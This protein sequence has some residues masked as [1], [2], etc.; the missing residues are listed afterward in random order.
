MIRV[1]HIYILF[2]AFAN[3]VYN[4][5]DSDI[6]LVAISDCTLDDLRRINES[7][8]S[9]NSTA[10]PTIVS[11]KYFFDSC[12]ITT[13]PDAV[14][15][16][17][18]HVKNLHFHDSNIIALATNALNGLRELEVL[19]LTGNVNL[20]RIQLWSSDI[21]EKCVKIDLNGNNIDRFDLLTLKNYPNLTELNLSNNRLARIPMGAFDF[22]L[23][24]SILN[25]ENNRLVR[26]DSGIFKTLIR[27]EELNLASNRI[28]FFDSFTFTTMAH[29]KSLRLD[30]NAIA[31]LPELAFFNLD[32]LE[33][34]NLKGNLLAT[35]DDRMFQ[36][37]GHLQHLDI[38]YNRVERISSEAFAGLKSLE[39][40]FK[41]KNGRA[42]KHN[43]IIFVFQTL[44]ISNNQINSILATAFHDLQQLKVLDVASNKLARV[45]DNRFA[46]LPMIETIALSHNE[47]TYI[48]EFAFT[49]L[50]AL[51]HLD[52][53]YNQLASDSFVNFQSRVKTLNLSHNQYKTFNISILSAIGFVNL[54]LNPWNCT[55]L[56]NEFVK[57]EHHVTEIQFGRPLNGV[58]TQA[59]IKQKAEDVTCYN[60]RQADNQIPRSIILIDPHIGA[61]INIAAGTEIVIDQVLHSKYIFLLL[62]PIIAN[63]FLSF[64]RKPNWL[65]IR[66]LPN[67]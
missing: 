29:L 61:Q 58:E 37:N 40:I 6:N 57:K 24:L 42:T 12:D 13:I 27:L 17:L 43:F 56:S 38:S 51:K 21:L 18:P 66:G 32:R 44:I 47:I 39:V 33:V 23:N 41:G 1:H 45:M 2:A 50:L 25:L 48:H 36:Q 31:A 19:T 7:I 22:S 67:C 53:S 63:I 34:L 20:T 46:Y 30:R 5:I 15:A 65:H 55:W 64:R 4:A 59:S 60:Y 52:L 26:L 10:K 16:N 28:K 11:D 8:E 35:I 14:F 54:T 62:K 49:D 9:G 3:V